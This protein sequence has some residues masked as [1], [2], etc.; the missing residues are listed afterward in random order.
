MAAIDVIASG[1]EEYLSPNPDEFRRFIRDNKPRGHVDKL[2]SAQAA[3]E[4]FV[5][6]GHY[7]CFDGNWGY[8]GP[9]LLLREV[10][11]QRKRNLWAAAGPGTGEIPILVGSGSVTRV[12]VGWMDPGPTVQLALREGRLKL[13]EWSNGGLSYRHLAGA[14]GVPF[15]PIRFLG[16]TDIF[17]H[18]GA[19]LVKDPFSGENI[20]LVPAI[21]P[22]VALIHVHQADR[23]GNA[24]VFGPGF[25]PFE[26]AASAKRVIV[27]TEELIE[28][29]E[30]RRQPGLTTIPFNVVDAVVHAPLGAYPGPMPG[31]YRA[32]PE[33]QREFREADRSGTMESY[34]DKW[35]YSV[36]NDQEMIDRYVMHETVLDADIKVS[37]LTHMRL[38]GTVGEAF[39]V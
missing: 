21:N 18:S 16:S 27:S 8:R 7:L 9:C 24:R 32:D 14:M 17:E 31:L 10:I 29:N 25:A 23:F 37:R 34:L 5:Q 30:T 22:D 11:R 26:K 39:G 1:R 20:V 35:M 33:H 2:M 28:P 13:T 19:K 12:D 6:D 36:E 4:R 3:I 15:L 38:A